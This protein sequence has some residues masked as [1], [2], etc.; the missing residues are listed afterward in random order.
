MERPVSGKELLGYAIHAGDGNI[1]KVI[2]LCFDDTTW[3]IR[4]L[5]VDVG[6]WLIHKTVLISPEALGRPDFENQCI[7]ASITREQVRHSPRV[8]TDGPFSLQDQARLHAHYGWEAY[9]VGDTFMGSPGSSYFPHEVLPRQ[10]IHVDPHLRTLT[11]VTGFRV[12]TQEGPVGH[13]QDIRITCEPWAVRYLVMRTDEGRVVDF[14]PST[15][16]KMSPEDGLIFLK[17][18]AAAGQGE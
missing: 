3:E 18:F 8:N 11:A 4:Y 10:E 17:T 12:C 14:P 5:V 9:W 7:P 15:I 6:K 1:G 2:E 13:L 16:T